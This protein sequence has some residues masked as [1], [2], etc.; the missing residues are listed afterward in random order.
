M[1]WNTYEIGP[2][3]MRWDHLGTVADKLA[4]LRNAE[5]EGGAEALHIG[6]DEFASAWESAQE[7]ASAAGWEGDFRQDPVV[8]WVPDDTEFS[9][10]FVIK[11]DNNGTTYVVSPVE[12]PHLED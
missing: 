7:A 2:I 3:D 6:P 8:F 11:Q 10:G 1:R 4:E 5:R 12:L 9:F